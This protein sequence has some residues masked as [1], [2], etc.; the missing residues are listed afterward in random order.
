MCFF[1]NKFNVADECLYLLMMGT[2]GN[3]NRIR[4]RSDSK[5]VG[6]D[7]IQSRLKSSGVPWSRLESSGVVQNRPELVGDEVGGADSC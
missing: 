4:L 6:N 2:I 5:N 3:K 1:L 7:T